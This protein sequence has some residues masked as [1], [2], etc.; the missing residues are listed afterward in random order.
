MEK[1]LKEWNENRNQNDNSVHEKYDSGSNWSR[2]QIEQGSR[3]RLCRKPAASRGWDRRNVAK[4]KGHT[5]TL[6]RF[7]TIV[8]SASPMKKVVVVGEQCEATPGCDEGAT[9]ERTEQA[10]AADHRRV[11]SV[12]PRIVF[13]RR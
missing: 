10:S 3:S 6:S 11:H 1:D 4:R 7:V 5:V 12:Y 9:Q 13:C 2:E 8:A